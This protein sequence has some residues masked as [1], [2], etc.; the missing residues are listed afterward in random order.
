MD[1]RV[2]Y[3]KIREAEKMIG[4][5]FAVVVSQETPDGGRAGVTTEV[6]RSIAAKMLVEG[7]ARPATL[8][9]AQQHHKR[10]AELLRQ[11]KE[12]EARERVHLTVIS[13][14]EMRSL[15]NSNRG[16]Q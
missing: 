5:D 7:K 2:Y 9:E 13:D 15:K 12:Q 8:E 6:P 14:S 4:G 11:A 16:K 10:A 3:R 1:L